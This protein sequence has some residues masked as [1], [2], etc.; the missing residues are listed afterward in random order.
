M[1]VCLSG[2]LV[3]LVLLLGTPLPGMAAELKFSPA[4]RVQ[5][6][7]DSNISFTSTHAVQDSFTTLSPSVMLTRQTERSSLKIDGQVDINRYANKQRFNE[8]EQVYG[9]EGEF[10][11]T[12]R[13]RLGLE[14]LF[15]KD[16]SLEQ[17]LEE[18]GLVYSRNDRD[19]LRV[20]PKMSWWLSELYLLRLSG[21]YQKA[22]YDDPEYLDYDLGEALVELGHAIFS[23]RVI[24]FI[25][26]GYSIADYSNDILYV[27]DDPR[28]YRLAVR[29]A[30]T[31]D[32]YGLLTGFD[33][34]LD[35]RWK[36]NVRWG[37]RET[38]F[39]YAPFLAVTRPVQGLV[40]SESYRVQIGY[41][42]LERLFERGGLSFEVRKNIVPS[43]RDAS[44]ER[45]SARCEVDYAFT[46]V[47]RGEVRGSWGRS[48]SKSDYLL[49][50]QTTSTVTLGGTYRL[51]E[52]LEA[53]LGYHYRLLRD[54]HLQTTTRRHVLSLNLR[55]AWEKVM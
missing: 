48:R 42:T 11:P 7:Y 52:R 39:E 49:T 19:V 18:T 31:V 24:F 4:L 26:G 45:L 5:E 6:G 35:P 51:G 8:T 17:E 20:A 54:H 38:T 32:N 21:A 13:M 41:V 28:G 47:L 34:A 46:E 16:S 55:F 29:P 30:G 9:L 2:W 3:V 23:Q 50:D 36:L 10:T 25:D 1:V 37:M 40:F 27:Y 15:R 14:G 22:L 43:G 44:V 33:L 53:G 12:R